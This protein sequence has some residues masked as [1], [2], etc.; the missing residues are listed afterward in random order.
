MIKTVLTKLFILLWI[1]FSLCFSVDVAAHKLMVFAGVEGMRINGQVYISGGHKV[2]Q[3]QIRIYTAAMEKPVATLTSDAEGHFNYLAQAAVKHRVAAY[4][5]DGHHAEW[6]L[7]ADE[8]T[9]EPASSI[10]TEQQSTTV[11]NPAL[12]PP[13]VAPPI[14]SSTP[15]SPSITKSN[16]QLQAIIERAVA[17]QIRP[18]REELHAAQQRAR[19]QDILGGLGYIFGLV[20]IVLW[21][22]QRQH[23]A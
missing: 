1:L 7:E 15:Q 6:W 18:L 4:T 14:Q 11:S 2:A 10:P 16:A 17:K 12:L 9:V 23:N 13:V 8:F 20:G 3:A 19:W 5:L 21:W 22:Q